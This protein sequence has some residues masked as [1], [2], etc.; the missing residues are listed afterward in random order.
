MSINYTSK[1]FPILQLKKKKKK[2]RL[3]NKS[4]RNFMFIVRKSS[5]TSRDCK[6]YQVQRSQYFNE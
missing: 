4:T 6:L 1:L 5:K 2:S 3:Q